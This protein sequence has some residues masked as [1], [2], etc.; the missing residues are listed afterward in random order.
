M[1]RLLDS[2]DAVSAEQDKC[3]HDAGLYESVITRPPDDVARVACCKKCHKI[4][5]SLGK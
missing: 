5:S 3:P 2:A 1:P 4:I